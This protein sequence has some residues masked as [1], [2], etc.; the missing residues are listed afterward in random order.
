[1]ALSIS[2]VVLL[3]IIMFILL[4]NGSLRAMPAIV[5]VLFGFFLASSGL[6]PSIN[7]TL[8][9]LAAAVRSIDF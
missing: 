1:M 8:T 9:S 6:A 7:N 4:R 5:A 3:L 2:A